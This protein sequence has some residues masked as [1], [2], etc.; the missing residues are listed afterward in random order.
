MKAS[1]CLA[2]LA[3]LA[4][5]VTVVAAPLEQAPPP[6]DTPRKRDLDSPYANTAIGAVID[7]NGGHVP[8]TSEE[9]VKTLGKLGDFV[10]LPV[11]FSAVALHSGLKHPRVILTMRPSTTP[12]PK[13][14]FVPDNKPAPKPSGGLGGW[15]WGGGPSGKTVLIPQPPEPLSKIAVNRTQLQGR[16]FLAANMELTDDGVKVRTV[17]FISW[18]TRKLKFEFGVIEGLG[19]ETPELKILDGVRCVSCHK[20]RGP[21]L[22]VAPWSNTAHNSIVQKT[23]TDLRTRGQDGISF[24]DSHGPEVDAA[25]RIGGDLLRDRAIFK[26]LA[27][28]DEGRKALVLL[29]N[30]V[31]ARGSLE[32]HDKDIAATLNS[33]AL[34]RFTRNA[35]TAKLN[36]APS[37]LRDFS[38][39]GP[40]TR[41]IVAWVGGVQ[42]NQVE[43]YDAA[44]ATGHPR[45]PTEFLPSN[46]KAFAPP[47]VKPTRQPS[48]VVNAVL[49]AQTIGLTEK[50]RE[51]LADALD[52]AVKRLKNPAFTP[53]TV[54]NAIFTGPAFADVLTTGNLPDRDDFKDR[55]VAGIVAVLRSQKLN[56]EFWKTRDTYASAPKFDPLAK[57]EK[58]LV[59]LPSHACMACHDIRGAK[60]AFNPI[61]ALAFD[62]FDATARDAWLKGADRKQKAEVLARLVKRLGTDKDMPP[63]DSTEAAMYR[64]KDPAALNTVQGWLDAELKKVK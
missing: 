42:K 7:T 45:L 35:I 23:L 25:V 54:A 40:V 33:P 39:A 5:A 43:R 3:A 44:R 21:I 30:T 56:D 55:F 9:L 63:D 61:P 27:E 64:V 49:L 62:P 48:D 28:S 60:A 52:E 29:F 51:F 26:Q 14:V 2:G 8:A 12:E 24:N 6:S 17:E 10:Q 19:S 58:E 16:L 22:G 37:T 46:P 4:L 13:S 20:N 50:D 18:N 38:P 31:V 36:A 11:P 59:A 57:P 34:A 15:G 53:A 1:A 47:E 41:E 32:K